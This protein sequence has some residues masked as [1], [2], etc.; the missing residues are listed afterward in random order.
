MAEITLSHV[1]RL[2]TEQGS[3]VSRE[4]ALAF[5]NQ[6]GRAFVF[7]GGAA[8]GMRGGLSLPRRRLS[9]TWEPEAPMQTEKSQVAEPQGR[10]YGCGDSGAEQRG[11]AG[12][13]STKGWSEGAVSRGLIQ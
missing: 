6:E 12:K 7:T 3:P 5:L 10:E 4:Q 13:S 2:A 8:S 1:L 9:G 11:V